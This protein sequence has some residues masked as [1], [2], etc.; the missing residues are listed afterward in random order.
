MGLLDHRRQW[1][2]EVAGSPAQCIDAFMRAF[3]GSGGLVAKASWDLSPTAEGAMAVYKGRRGI[4]ALGS[5]MSQ[6]VAFEQDTALGS[7]VTLEVDGSS[8]GRTQCSMWLSESGR[9]GIAGL[10]G[11]TSDARFIRPY[12]QAVRDEMLVLD[13]GARITSG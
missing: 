13:P 10:F 7:K 9:A 12:M 1:V 11:V 4:G 6:T 3:T 8:G 2:F 5:V